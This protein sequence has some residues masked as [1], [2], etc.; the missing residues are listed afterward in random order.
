[1]KTDWLGPV[2]RILIA[3]RGADLRILGITSPHRGSGVSTLAKQV[4]ENS[5]R[6]GI[7]TLLVDLTAPVSEPASFLPSWTPGQPGP[8]DAIKTLTA[9]YE[10]LTCLPTTETQ[11]LFNNTQLL[12][13]TLDTELDQYEIVIVDLPA[14]LVKQADLLSRLALA[15]ICDAVCMVC[16]TGRETLDEL[17]TVSD[18]LKTARIRLLSIVL[19]D[20]V[21]PK[22][23][24]RL[25]KRTV[26]SYQFV[27]TDYS[28]PRTQ[29]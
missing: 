8:Q 27:R 29:E 12:R 10:Q 14:L 6:S 11:F 7:R 5:S 3:A 18:M 26:A 22:P 16:V 15:A 28:R 23:A 1:M 21:S 13:R 17:T 2:Q 20:G 19:N 25:E 24:K 4:A 9:G